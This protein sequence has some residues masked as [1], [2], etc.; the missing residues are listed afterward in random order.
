MLNEKTHL[1]FLDKFAGLVP[2]TIQIRKLWKEKE[3]LKKELDREIA[4][5]ETA[6]LQKAYLEAAIEE[7]GF[8]DAQIGEEEKLDVERRQVKIIKK[9]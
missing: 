4:H 7:I 5:Q 3:L 1:Q 8:F 2:M 6:K 9:K